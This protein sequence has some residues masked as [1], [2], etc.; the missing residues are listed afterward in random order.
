MRLSWPWSPAIFILSLR[1]PQR[2]TEDVLKPDNIMITSPRPYPNTGLEAYGI[3]PG[4]TGSGVN[5]QGCCLE[6]GMAHNCRPQGWMETGRAGTLHSIAS[7]YARGTLGTAPEDRE[8]TGYTCL[9]PSLLEISGNEDQEQA[10]S[11]NTQQA[12]HNLQRE[13]ASVDTGLSPK[14]A[15]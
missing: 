8:D 5:H 3:N 11:W 13:V 1:K 14:R 2:S 4:L 7:G 9:T 10:P 15:Y 6:L 12:Q